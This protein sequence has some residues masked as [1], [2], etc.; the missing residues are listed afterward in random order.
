MVDTAADCLDVGDTAMT[1][2]KKPQPSKYVSRSVYKGV[3]PI[4]A[5]VARK[6]AEA[7][8]KAM[9]KRAAAKEM[10]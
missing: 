10:A 6:E 7:L 5:G 8:V 1:A 4:K 3:R 2:V 9:Q